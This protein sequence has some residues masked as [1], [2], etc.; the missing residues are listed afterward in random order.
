MR[1]ACALLVGLIAFSF[2]AA[3]LADPPP[4]APAHGKKKHN[5]KEERYYVGYSGVEYYRDLDI[6]NGRCDRE[7]VGAV[8]GGVVGGA[9]GNEVGDRD[10]RVVA[11]IIG[12]AAGALI[13]AQIGREMDER[14]RACFGHSLELGST[15]HRVVW[16]ASGVRYELVPGHGSHKKGKKGK[17]CRN[18]TLVAI[19]S[20][21]RIDRHGKACQSRPGVWVLV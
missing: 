17:V 14:D 13:G 11:T 16:V 6:P 4:W 21:N 19:G 7:K 3:T 12:A 5:G 18:F 9:I 2:S 8:L 10:E 15:G 20:H 1:K